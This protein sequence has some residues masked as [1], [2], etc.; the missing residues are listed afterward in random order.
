MSTLSR[1]VLGEL[2]KVFAIALSAIT[3]LF[4]MFGIVNQ[5][6][7]ENLGL[8]QIVLLLPY[9]LPEAL[10][11]AVPAAILLATCSVY[12]RFSASNEV[13]AVKSMGI[14]PMV[15]IWPSLMRV[16][17]ESS[18]GSR[19]PFFRSNSVST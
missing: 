9:V 18:T 10:R 3:G 2:L 6:V 13:V 15:V 12:G 4:V 7:R 16:D 1:Y 17:A 14:S 11:F 8:T 19:S 5:A